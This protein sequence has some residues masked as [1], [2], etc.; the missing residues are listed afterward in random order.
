M[1][2]IFYNKE[3]QFN[4]T[5]E[6]FDSFIKNPGKKV[7]IPR[8]NVFLS[9]MFIWAGEKP[10]EASNSRLL[11]DGTRAFNKFGVWVLESNHDIK[12][13]INYYPELKEESNQT[14]IA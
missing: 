3:S 5:D 14:L 11:K 9:D 4:L 12:I 2:T 10:K 13:D 6:E 7:F 8:L 1:K